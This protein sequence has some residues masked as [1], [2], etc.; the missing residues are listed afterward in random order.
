MTRLQAEAR[1]LDGSHRPITALVTRPGRPTRT[2]AARSSSDADPSAADDQGLDPGS[3]RRNDGQGTRWHQA[4]SVSAA[5]PP[6][7]SP[8]RAPSTPTQRCSHSTIIEALDLTHWDWSTGS[9]PCCLTWLCETDVSDAGNG[10]SPPARRGAPGAF[11]AADDLRGAV[12]G[13]DRVEDG[14]GGVG[15]DGVVA[16]VIRSDLRARAGPAGR[17]RNVRVHAGPPGP[18]RLS[19][20]TA[21]AAVVSGPPWPADARPCGPRRPPR[22]RAG[23]ARSST[24]SS[25]R[26]GRAAR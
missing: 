15:V 25:L 3:A 10:I 24:G 6:L 13:A 18:L 17:V 21:A 19:R 4:G 12:L 16:P 26:A 7:S 14:D 22:R 9:G 20:P 23:H 5:R 2:P 1:S 8:H 11:V